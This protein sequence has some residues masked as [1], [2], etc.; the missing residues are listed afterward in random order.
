V[1]TS[2][3]SLPPT[4]IDPTAKVIS[5]SCDMTTEADSDDTS[6][7]DQGE[8]VSEKYSW[9]TLNTIEEIK[10][11]FPP[12]SHT[13][14]HTLMDVYAQLAQFKLAEGI[15]ASTALNSSIRNT[16]DSDVSSYAEQNEDQFMNSFDSE[17]NEVQSS[18]DEEGNPRTFQSVFSKLMDSSSENPGID[19]ML[20]KGFTEKYQFKP[21]PEDCCGR[22]ASAYLCSPANNA[23]LFACMNALEQDSDLSKL[24]LHFMYAKVLE[25]VEFFDDIISILRRK[26]KSSEPNRL[27]PKESGEIH[28]MAHYHTLRALGRIDFPLGKFFELCVKSNRASFES[29]LHSSMPVVEKEDLVDNIYNC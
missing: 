13:Q 19:Q 8:D 18:E 1:L 24:Q 4:F 10:K 14:A 7:S 3:L 25:T 20:F 9:R 28:S 26:S 2:P 27:T 6:Q 11:W 5:N 16:E 12:I 29:A 15:E 23:K 17:Q 21:G 22:Q